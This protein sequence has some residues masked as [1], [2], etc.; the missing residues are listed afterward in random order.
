MTTIIP[1]FQYTMLKIL[2]KKILIPYTR[3]FI[4]ISF[5]YPSGSWGGVGYWD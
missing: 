2:S 3:V 5:F 4:F 1:V